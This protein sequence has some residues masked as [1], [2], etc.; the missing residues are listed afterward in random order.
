MMLETH[1]VCRFSCRFNCGSLVSRE[2]KGEGD[3]FRAVLQ[4]RLSRRNVLKVGLVAGAAAALGTTLKASAA[5]AAELKPAAVPPSAAVAVTAAAPVQQ[6][7][8]GLAFSAIQP[9]DPKTDEIRVADGH[10]ATVLIGWGDPLFADVPDFDLDGQTAALQ[11]RR[12]GFNSDFVAFLPLPL[13]S[14]TAHEGLIWNNHEYTDGLMMF[15]DYDPAAPTKEQVDIEL[16]AHGAS[17]VLAR[18]DANGDWAYD[19]TSTYNRRI[20]GT[21]PIKISGPAAGDEWLKTSADPS[22]TVS[23]GMLNNCGGGWTPWGTILTA[24]ENFNQYFANADGLPADD[25]R[26]KTHAR[27]GMPKAASER[28]WEQFYDRFDIAKEPNEPFRFGWIVEVDPYDPSSQPVKRT[29]LGRFKH[30]AAAT[31]VASNGKVVVYTGD[32]ERFDYAYKFVSDGIYNPNDRGANKDLL[33]SGTLYVAKFN[34]DGTG[35]WL[36]LTFGQGPLT[37]ANGW[38]N[39]ADVLIRARQA[40]DALGATKMDRPEDIE[41]SPTTG[42]VYMACTNNTQRGTEGRAPVDKANPRATNAFGH[43]IEWSESGGN[44]AAITFGWEIFM[45]CGK[46]EDEST[47]FAGFAKE[48]VSPIGSPDNLA[49]DSRGNLWIATDGQPSNLKVNDAI[50]AVPVEGAERGHLRQLF[51]SV[52]GSEVASLVFNPDDTALFTSIQHP[53][54]GGK[55]SAPTSV[56]PT[57][58]HARPSLV[59]VTS[60][61]GG[62]VGA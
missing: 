5:E 12:F 43:I 20:T 57:G 17:I 11:E 60:T 2:P 15:P 56:W 52:S 59:V 55:L 31:V 30:E 41:A 28:L 9:T 7:T 29:A 62:I 25:L 58:V 35:Q 13:G 48:Q 16:A 47:Y 61:R 32:D 24:E 14:R 53:G 36:P 34:D 21:T 6:R 18:R 10:K 23:A 39:Q 49:F 54:E 3:T 1:S 38:R 19:R 51:S 44:H 40:S 4:R 27:L 33:D 8:S 46:P 22:G 26:S 42:K 37:A 45:L 50:H